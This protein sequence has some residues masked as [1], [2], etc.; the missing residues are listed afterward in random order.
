[1]EALA[2]IHLEA[3]WFLA[4]RWP[5]IRRVAAELLRTGRLS[6]RRVRA[7]AR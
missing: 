5:A 1:M 2:R 6:G 7:L 4:L 3:C